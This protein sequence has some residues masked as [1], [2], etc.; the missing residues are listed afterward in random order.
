LQGDTAVA[1]LPAGHAI[2]LACEV[3]YGILGEPTASG[4]ADDP[5]PAL[6]IERTKAAPPSTTRSF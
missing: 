4:E 5:A 3:R 2:D 1:H 6:P